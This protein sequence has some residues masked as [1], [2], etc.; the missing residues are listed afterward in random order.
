MAISVKLQTFQGPLDLLLHLISKNKVSITDIPIA[1]ITDQYLEY[2]SHMEREDLDV[3]SEFLVMAATLLQIK[4]R[5]LLPVPEEESEEETDPREELMQR[6]L[7]YKMYKEAALALREKMEGAERILFRSPYIPEEV[8]AFKEVIDPVK[9]VSDAGL[10]TRQLASAFMQVLQRQKESRD[11]IRSH[12]GTIA[13]E[14]V[15]MAQTM[16]SVSDTLKHK[17]KLSFQELLTHAGSRSEVVVTFL[18]ILELMKVGAVSTSQKGLFS[19]IDLTYIGTEDQDFE[20]MGRD[21]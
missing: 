17:K 16:R 15:S 5:M 6:L 4:A 7:E 1:S 18:C 20:A 8:A 3:M 13:R 19:E 12:F 2:L 10:T 14:E 9:L 21:Y 11:P